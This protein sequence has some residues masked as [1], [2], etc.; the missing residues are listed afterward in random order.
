MNGYED[1]SGK[2]I[3]GY[4]ELVARLVNEFPISSQIIG[5]DNEKNLSNCSVAF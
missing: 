1:D 2:H 5:E 4:N 3:E